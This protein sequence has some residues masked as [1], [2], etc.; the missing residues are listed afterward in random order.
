MKVLDILM[1]YKKFS[2]KYAF[3]SEID[4]ICSFAHTDFYTILHIHEF[5]TILIYNKTS[6]SDF[7]KENEPYARETIGI[8]SGKEGE[9]TDIEKDGD[10]YEFA[11]K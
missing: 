5:Q 2:Q 1:D 3:L 6:A 9:K 7:E 8:D 10:Y 4:C 11:K